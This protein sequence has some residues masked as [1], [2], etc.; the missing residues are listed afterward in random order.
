MQAVLANLYEH[1]RTFGFVQ[2]LVV[3]GWHPQQQFAKLRLEPSIIQ[4]GEGK[5]DG[6]IGIAH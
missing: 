2:G 4:L 6:S 5:Q 1:A 3:L